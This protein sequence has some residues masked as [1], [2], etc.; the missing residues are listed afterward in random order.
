MIV[1]HMDKHNMKSKMG[2]V[3]LETA[4]NNQDDI[5]KAGVAC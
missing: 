3:Y 1:V 5:I 4:Q 2:K